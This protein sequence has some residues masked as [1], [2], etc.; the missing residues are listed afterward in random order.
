MFLKH[1]YSKPTRNRRSVVLLFD[2]NRNKF[3]RYKLLCYLCNQTEFFVNGQEQEMEADRAV[4][5]VTLLIVG[6]YID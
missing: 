4:K 6:I 1:T 5:F 3:C 2:D